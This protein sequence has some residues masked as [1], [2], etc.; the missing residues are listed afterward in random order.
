MFV[1]RWKQLIKTAT[2]FFLAAFSCAV[3]WVL[4]SFSFPQ[5]ETRAEY[6]L[7]TPSS[8]AKRTPDLSPQDALFLQGVGYEYQTD[9]GEVFAIKQVRALRAT[10]LKTERVGNICSYYCYSPALGKT[11]T[12]LGL[13]V[14]LHI[15]VK[16]NDVKIGSPLVFGGY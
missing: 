3:L 2:G 13:K 8:Q 7:Y 5:G 14:N 4:N 9:D 1:Y 6:Y 10:V 16:G 12:V 11:V 15:V